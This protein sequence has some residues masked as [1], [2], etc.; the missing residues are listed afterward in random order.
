MLV[1]NY[2]K[3]MYFVSDDLV[4]GRFLLHERIKVD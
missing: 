1:K 4:R 3:H 2:I